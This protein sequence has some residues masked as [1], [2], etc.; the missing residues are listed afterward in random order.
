M[1]YNHG[2]AGKLPVCQQENGY[3][4]QQVLIEADIS[5]GPV[6]ITATRSEAVDFAWPMWYDSSTML[7]GLGKPEVDPWG[8]LLPLAP[9]VWVGILTALLVGPTAVFLSSSCFSMKTSRWSSYLSNIYGFI[10]V[11]LQQDISV[12][13]DWWW[14]RMVFGIWMMMTLVLT[15]SYAGNLMSSLAVRHIPQPYQTL[16][17]VI[18]D[19]SATMIWQKNSINAE[20]LRVVKS[21]IIREVADL[22]DEGRLA[23]HTQMEYPRIVDTLVR[24]GEYVLFGIDVLLRN[25]MAKDFTRK[26]SIESSV[27]L[28]H[29][30]EGTG[31]DVIPWQ[32]SRYHKLPKTFLELADS[33][34]IPI[35]CILSLYIKE[36]GQA[37]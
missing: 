24:Q 31:I 3:L 5:I 26:E 22:E 1:A 6:S 34:Q 14:E 17:D 20:Y 37:S 12:P 25:L 19:P 2:Y 30:T 4:Q 28:Q 10:R 16:R 21:G 27:Y 33:V 35:I 9:L 29:S 18:D 36:H 15:R 13:A 11:L 7:A 32:Q 23:Y 8:F